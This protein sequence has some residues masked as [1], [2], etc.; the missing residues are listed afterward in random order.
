MAVHTLGNLGYLAFDRGE[1]GRGRKLVGESIACFRT[2]NDRRY[3][4]WGYIAA[5][6]WPART[7]TPRPRTGNTRRA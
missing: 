7:A 3:L 5:A 1:R 6:T 4:A 2:F